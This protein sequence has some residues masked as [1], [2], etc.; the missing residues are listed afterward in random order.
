MRPRPAG[1]GRAP[2]RG[3]STRAPAVPSARRVDHERRDVLRADRAPSA[4]R[5]PPRRRAG[6]GL[7][8][9]SP[10]R[11]SQP[12]AATCPPCELGYE[13]TCSSSSPTATALDPA[14]AFGEHLRAG[15]ALGRGERLRRADRGAARP[16]SRDDPLV[17]AH[18]AL[19]RRTGARAGRRARRRTGPA[20]TGSPSGRA[21]DRL[22]T[23]AGS[24][25]RPAA[26]RRSRGRG[27]VQP[28]R[29]RRRR[30]GSRR[31]PSAPPMR[32]RTPMPSDSPAETSSTSPL[33]TEVCSERCGR[34]APLRRRSGPAALPI[35]S[36]RRSIVTTRSRTGRAARPRRRAAG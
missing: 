8:R 21:R 10:S 28:R 15:G 12:A 32:T 26:P 18:A 22:P 33:R 17:A 24:R 34:G 5:P 35:S 16:R 2:A 6:H 14:A 27:P 4:V 29:R 13:R 3:R 1:C 7:A 20:R 36:C 30:R 19:R 9:S 11:C 23:R 25:A 31:S